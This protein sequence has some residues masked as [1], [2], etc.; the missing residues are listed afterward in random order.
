MMSVSDCPPVCSTKASSRV[1]SAMLPSEIISRRLRSR[2]SAH[3]PANGDTRNAGTKP[4]RM[5]TVMSTPDLVVSVTCHMSAYC[6]SAVPNN[7]SAWL[8]R[9]MAV[10]RFQDIAGRMAE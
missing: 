10:V 8:V 7:D 4:H 1:T 3:T 9:K 6:T 2:R 5:Y